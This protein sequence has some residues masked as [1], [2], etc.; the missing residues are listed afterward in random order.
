MD[1][2][3]I[4]KLNIV[5][6]IHTIIWLFFNVVIFY[7]FYAVI[8]NKIDKFLWICIG[9]FRHLHCLTDISVNNYLIE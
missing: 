9:S 4:S 1:T 5:K 6:T 7:L 3:A 8:N 2:T